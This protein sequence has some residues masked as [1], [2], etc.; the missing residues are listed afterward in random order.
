MCA[1]LLDPCLVELCQ[2]IGLMFYA[3]YKN[4]TE[5]CS[6]G[7]YVEYVKTSNLEA[8]K[9]C[10]ICISIAFNDNYDK[11]KYFIW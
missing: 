2:N 11:G 6:T 1:R 8:K 10:V 4:K 9:G 5:L 3:G 7:I